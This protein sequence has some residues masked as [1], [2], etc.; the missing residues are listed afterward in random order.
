[1]SID[2]A[3]FVLGAAWATHNDTSEGEGYETKG[4]SATYE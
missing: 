4:K 3:M 2:V 1:M